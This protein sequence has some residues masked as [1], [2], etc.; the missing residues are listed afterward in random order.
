VLETDLGSS[1]KAVSPFNCHLSN[2]K[3]YVDLNMVIN[4]KFAAHG[5]TKAYPMLAS[6]RR[7]SNGV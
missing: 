2:S 7:D 6:Q 3:F 5:K 1:A 4:R